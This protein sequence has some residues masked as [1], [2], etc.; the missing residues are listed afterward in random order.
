V[1]PPLN[2]EDDMYLRFEPI[3]ETTSGLNPFEVGATFWRRLGTEF[4]GLHW[5]VHALVELHTNVLAGMEQ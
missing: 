2:I 1:V 5:M 3:D 4:L